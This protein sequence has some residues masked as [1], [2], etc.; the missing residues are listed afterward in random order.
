MV[1]CFSTAF[2]TVVAAV[3]GLLNVANP[4]GQKIPLNS[5]GS[6]TLGGT[7]YKTKSLCQ[8]DYP[9]IRFWNESDWKTH[10]KNMKASSSE[11]TIVSDYMEGE[12][13]NA[14]SAVRAQEI[15]AVAFSLWFEILNKGRAPAKWS[16][17]AADV[18]NFYY[19]CLEDK[20]PE[21]RYCHN[22]WKAQHLATKNYPSFHNNHGHKGLHGVVKQEPA[23]QGNIS[24]TVKPQ[25]RGH[26]DGEEEGTGK[27]TGAVKKTKRTHRDKLVVNVWSRL[28]HPSHRDSTNT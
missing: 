9:Q 15:R 18:K 1:Q 14:V 25:K 22:S 19:A 3:P 6:S 23:D 20:C 27:G 21:M 10:S 13:G 7:E 28:S 12:D 24:D 8:A 26:S 5:Q 17:A 16:E 11:R 4:F 2:S